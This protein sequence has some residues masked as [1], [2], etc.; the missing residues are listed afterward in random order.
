[1]Q[2]ETRGWDNLQE[3]NMSLEDLNKPVFVQGVFNDQV[4][5]PNYE[6]SG[7]AP[8]ALN[9]TI[10][11]LL[12]GQYS[13]SNFINLFYCLPEIFA[14][15]NEIA[16]RVADAVWQLRRNQDDAVDY[17]DKD[18]NRL[19]SQPNPLMSHKQL[20]WQAVCYELLTGANL[21]FF[22]KPSTL[23]DDYTNILTWSNMPTHKVATN[24]KKGVDPYTATSLSDFVSSYSI[25]TRIF[26]PANVLAIANHDLNSGNEVDKF[27]SPLCGAKLAIRNLLPVYEARGVIYIK[28]GALGFIVSK[29]SDMSGTISLTPNEKKDAQREY[30]HSF[31]LSAG[32][33]QVG[34]TSA[35]VD[36]IKTS[37]SIQEL[38][39]FDETLADAVAIYKVLRVPRHLVPSKDTSTFNNA[40]A[41][42]KSFYGDVIIPLANKYA[43][44]WTNH[45][46]IPNR[47]IYA[48]FSTV[49][50]L[51]EDRKEKASV[52]Q[53]NGNVWLQRWTSGVCTLNDWIK[54]NE[55]DVGV[56]RI[57]ENKI[58]DLT[59]DEVATVKNIINL[60]SV[61]PGAPNGAS[62]STENPS[63]V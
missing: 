50:I 15:V 6:Y 24:K 10:D 33:N 35:P 3:N 61:S 5:F 57:Y 44:N 52:D 2:I 18:F 40:D 59:A 41:D 16:S 60:K 62:S 53:I 49:A 55:G 37:M 39:P 14:P 32:Q 58:F 27:L 7:D 9:R 25:G 29:K 36:F 47:Y 51:Q 11:S 1:M 30:S 38:Q 8:A 13:Q 42:M 23:A 12:Y 46:K 45:F 17:K 34:V 26:D 43:Q 31:G 56:G 63:I 4:P 20:V 28:R 54:A 22:N 48:D 21:E 19:F